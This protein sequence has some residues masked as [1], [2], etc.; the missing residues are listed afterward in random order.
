MEAGKS[1]IISVPPGWLFVG[2]ISEETD[3]HIT[4]REGVWLESA[5][6]SIMDLTQPNPKV[7]SIITRSSPAAGLEIQRAAIT[8][9]IPIK[10]SVVRTLFHG[11]A[12]DA[13]ENAE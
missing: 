4:C 10:E 8:F 11:K 3:T 5:G 13:V 1:Y 12:L 7:K 6:A 2:T 9:S